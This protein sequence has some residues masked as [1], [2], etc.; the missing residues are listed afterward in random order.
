MTVRPGGRVAHIGTFAS[1]ALV[2]LWDIME[3]LDAL[4]RIAA[5]EAVTPGEAR[6]QQEAEE[7][8]DAAAE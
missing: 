2:R 5:G 4:E 8:A 7:A 6:E 1:D 3:E